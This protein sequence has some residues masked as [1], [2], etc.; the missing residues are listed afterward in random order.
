MVRGHEIA[1][2]AYMLP[3]AD[4]MS[5]HRPRIRGGS[6]EDNET[7]SRGARYNTTYL[8]NQ[9]AHVLVVDLLQHFP[10]V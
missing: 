9:P 2:H 1:A 6:Q 7:N 10:A 3:E 5:G 8:R 4:E